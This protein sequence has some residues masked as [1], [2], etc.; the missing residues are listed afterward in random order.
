M[1]NTDVTLGAAS[2]LALN[3]QERTAGFT[4]KFEIDHTDI[5]EGTALDDT[6]TVSLGSLPDNFVVSKCFMYV[7]EAFDYSGDE[8]GTLTVQVGTDGDPNNYATAANLIATGTPVAAGV[9]V[10]A[11]SGVIPTAA[12]SAGESGD[13]LEALFT[14][15]AAGSPSLLNVGKLVILMEIAEG[16]L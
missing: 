7:K 11:A 12:G 3:N 4:H 16:L 9:V 14:N 13:A 2:V 5:D 1:A 10:G 15:S 6:V 8:A